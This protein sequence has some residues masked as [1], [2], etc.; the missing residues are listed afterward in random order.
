MP[1]V[2]LD[3]CCLIYLVEG[4]PSWK[5]AVERTV[6]GLDAEGGAAFISSELARLECR[7][8]PVRQRNGAL[9]ARYDELLSAE[10]LE[11]LAVS[12]AVIDHATELRARYGFKTLDA[13]HIATALVARADVFVTGDAALTKCAEVRV[14]V[15]APAP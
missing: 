9:L 7:T 8:K 2:Y 13:I 3:A 11:L 10:R 6:R 5:E 14:E 4:E 1:S 12:R 15:L